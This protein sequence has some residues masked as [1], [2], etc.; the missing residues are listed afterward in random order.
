[1][2]RTLAFLPAFVLSLTLVPATPSAGGR[3]PV[4]TTSPCRADASCPA[5]LQAPSRP[6]ST[7]CKGKHVRAGADLATASASKPAGTTF[8]LAAG[9][10][11]ISQTVSWQ[12]GDRIIGAGIG[13]TFIRPADVG[14][15]ITG[16]D[17]PDNTKT[18]T[19][20]RFDIGGFQADPSADCRQCGTAII[21][22][23]ADA[24][25]WIDLSRVRCHDNGT[26]CIGSG[27]GNIKATHL[28]CYGNGFHP[29]SLL[30]GTYRSASCVKMSRGSMTMRD[31]QIHGNVWN[32]IW[33]DYCDHT[34]W[35]IED[36]TFRNNGHAAIQWEISGELS[37]DTA[38]IRHNVIKNNGWQITVT[39]AVT[40]AGLVI[41]GGRNITVIGNTFGG[42]RY[43]DSVGGSTLLCCRGIGIWD[44]D[45]AAWDPNLQN[46]V[47]RDNDLDGDSILGCNY[48]G[49]TCK[50]N[51]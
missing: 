40:N 49:V 31:S 9:T 28:D 14:R 23:G 3:H 30:D 33:C 46:V 43:L 50:R 17:A 34:T 1:M 12:P 35:I 42:N 22:S 8:C 13:Q 24:Q 27:Y 18:V 5:P 37:T 15:P 32:G 38:L 10:F 45:R 19:F 26:V 11:T 21:D 4:G 29:G 51:T 39:G 20:S 2:K 7:S 48:G 16:F 44:D 41:S 25:G 36:T 47:I 6:H